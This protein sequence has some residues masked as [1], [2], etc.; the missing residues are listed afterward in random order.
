MERALYPRSI[1]R[2]LV[3]WRSDH[4]WLTLLLLRPLI[5]HATPSGL[6][7]ASIR[8]PSTNVPDM[9]CLLGEIRAWLVIRRRSANDFLV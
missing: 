7:N 4:T 1:D 2:I 6:T 3:S 8:S 9:I 5:D